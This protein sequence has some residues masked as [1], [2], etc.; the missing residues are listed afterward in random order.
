MKLHA[1]PRHSHP[2]HHHLEA[3]RQ[4]TLDQPDRYSAKNM[5]KPVPFVCRA[6]HA[7]KVA[8]IGDFNNWDET[9]HPMQRQPDGAWRLEIPL[10]HGHHRYRFVVDGRPMLDP[11]AHGSARDHH[12]GK[13]SLVAVS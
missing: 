3:L 4:Y 2:N 13:T 9:A 7:N 5:A 1:S 10:P 8:L 6:P 11:R 12:G